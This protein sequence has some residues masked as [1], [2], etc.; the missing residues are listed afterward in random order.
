MRSRKCEIW[1]KFS[2]INISLSIE[3]DLIKDFLRVD[4][5]YKLTDKVKLLL[6]WK[7][8]NFLMLYIKVTPSFPSISSVPPS[9]DLC[10]LQKGLLHYY[11]IHQ[12]EFFHC[13]V[14]SQKSLKILLLY[15]ILSWKG[16]LV[17][18]CFYIWYFLANLQPW[19]RLSLSSCRYLANTMEEDEEESKYEIFPWALGKNWK[20]LF[21]RFLEQRDKLW[22]R[23]EYRAAVSRRCCEEVHTS[24][25]AWGDW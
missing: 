14:S 1:F 20:K 23:I 21:P 2:Y 6:W 22:A 12:K 24:I 5:C 9:H 15:Y 10:V 25:I 3:D 13:T 16:N 18:F 7:L 11:W 4:G 17:C 19:T 8:Q